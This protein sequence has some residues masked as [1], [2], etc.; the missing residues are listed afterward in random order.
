MFY[1]TPMSEEQGLWHA[2]DETHLGQ[3]LVHTYQALLNSFTRVVGM[4]SARL[5]V[6]HVL[7]GSQPDGIGVL[8]IARSLDVNAA[9]VTRQIKAMESERLVTRRADRRD[10][11]RS[12]VRLTPKG[13]QLFKQIHARAHEFERTLTSATPREDVATTVRV[14][15]QIRTALSKLR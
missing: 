3:E 13:Q 14:L 2:P 4:P 6:M 12:F 9:A 15:K 11:R 7:Y 10:R 8:D 1:N 5:S